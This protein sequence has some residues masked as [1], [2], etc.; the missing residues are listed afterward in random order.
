MVKEI[1][2]IVTIALFIIAYA[3]DFFSGKVTLVARNP[4]V[5]LSSDTISRYPF[6]V[7]A[8][9]IRTLG[10]FLSL[11]LALTL[12][13]KKYFSKAGISLFLAVVAEA[14][15]IQ[16]MATG[17][18]TTPLQWTLSIAYTGALLIPMILIFIF[19]GIMSSI[20]RVLTKKNHV[21]SDA[22]ESKGLLVP[23]AVKEKN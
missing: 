16:Q 4:I 10:I 8:I 2:L 12:M 15:A 5:F 9:G 22:S 21:V 13:E 23:T 3:I 7:L 6:T 18:R 11:I 19:L 20:H 1:S 17:V 14:Y